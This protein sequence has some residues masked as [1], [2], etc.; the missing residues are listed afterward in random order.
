MTF[1]F[2]LIN[3]PPVN[4]PLVNWVSPLAYSQTAWVECSSY[5]PSWWVCPVRW[6][7]LRWSTCV[8]RHE[9]AAGGA[10]ALALSVSKT[11]CLLGC[12]MWKG[13]RAFPATSCSRSWQPCSL[14]HHSSP[15]TAC[16]SHKHCKHNMSRTKWTSFAKSNSWVLNKN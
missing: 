4:Q 9:R 12:E 7:Q 11:Y 10:A 6:G 15:S 1:S 16:R 14:R 5:Q 13:P 3:P 2:A 8:Q